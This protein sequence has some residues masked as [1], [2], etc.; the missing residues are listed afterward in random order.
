MSVVAEEKAAALGDTG[1]A[2][3]RAWMQEGYLGGTSCFARASG[4]DGLGELTWQSSVG[5]RGTQWALHEV[6]GQHLVRPLSEV[7]EMRVWEALLLGRVEIYRRRN[8]PLS[9][10]SSEV[11]AVL[12]CA[13]GLSLESGVGT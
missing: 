11:T 5:S 6:V 1:I 4:V 13:N 8:A 7:E 9:G 3:W 12:H 10:A 2:V